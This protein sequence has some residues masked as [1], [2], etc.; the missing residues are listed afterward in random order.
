MTV[1]VPYVPGMLDQRTAAW[2]GARLEN[3]TALAQLN[4]GNT[5]AYWQLLSAH[6]TSQQG[7]N[8]DLLIVEQDMLP[9]DGVVDE[10]L[11][12]RWPWCASPYE[13]ANH[14]T[15]TDGLGCTKFS[16]TL[17]QLR[18]QLMDEVGAIDDDGL[19][20]KDWRRLD[21]R[22]SRVLRG[23][24]HQPHLHK[25]STHLHDYQARP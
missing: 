25:P 3:N 19:P 1:I 21:T 14:Q 10:M 22:I 13:V 24:G 18:P 7:L 5:S 9:A 16:A 8:E 12:C 17:K 20:G 23:A 2:A 6:W 15:I 4:P 11:A